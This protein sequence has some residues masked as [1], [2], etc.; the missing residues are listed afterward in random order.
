[1]VK[2]SWLARLRELLD[3]TCRPRMRWRCAGTSTSPPTDA[4]VWDPAHFVG[5][6]HVTVPERDALA[7]VLDWGLVDVFGRLHPEGGVFSWWDYRGGDF[8]K[9]HGMRIDLVLLSEQLA[10]RCSRRT[11]TAS[12][13]EAAA[14]NS[15]SDHTPVV[16]GLARSRLTPRPRPTAVAR[17]R[18]PQAPRPDSGGT[19]AS[20]NDGPSAERA[21]SSCSVSSSAVVAR[22]AGTPIPAARAT[23]S[24]SGSERSSMAWARGPPRLRPDPVSSMLRMA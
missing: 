23:K 7:E 17:G 8:H 13:Q 12:P 1:M 11:S 3:E 10:E 4:D 20:I 5:A 9:G 14:G 6:T 16:V 2:L 15:P 24:R 18:C 22:V 21:R 19:I